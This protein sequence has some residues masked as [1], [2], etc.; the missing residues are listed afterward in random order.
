[1]WQR[2]G[3]F[4]R[5]CLVL[6]Q[7]TRGLMRRPHKGLGFFEGLAACWL[8]WGDPLASGV[9]VMRPQAIEHKEYPHQ[10]N[11]PEFVEKEGWYHGDAPADGGLRGSIVA[12]CCVARIIRK[13]DVHDHTQSLV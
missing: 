1:G 7:G 8:R 10:S 12:G 6:T 13:V 2:R 9:G 3:C 5:R 4:G 11:E